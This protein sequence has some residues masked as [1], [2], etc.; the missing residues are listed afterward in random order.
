MLPISNEITVAY[1]AVLKKRAVPVTRHADYRKWLRYFLDF[2]SKY[3]LS[4]L[5]SEQVRL[6]IQKLK[7]KK[8]TT[9]QQKRSPL[10]F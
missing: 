4:D 2:R 5:R 8:Q 1:D 3:T 10:G 7:E 6:F 9:E